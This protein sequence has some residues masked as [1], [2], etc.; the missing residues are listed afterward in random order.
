MI[1]AAGYHIWK[2]QGFCLNPLELDAVSR[3]T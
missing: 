3:W 1:A 2:R